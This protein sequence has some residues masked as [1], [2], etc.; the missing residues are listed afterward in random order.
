M[1]QEDEGEAEGKSG[2]DDRRQPD[3][4]QIESLRGH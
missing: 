3:S 4:A 1:P 2:G